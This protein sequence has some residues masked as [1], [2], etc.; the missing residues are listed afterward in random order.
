[1][2]KAGGAALQPVGFTGASSTL[3]AASGDVHLY[4]LAGQSNMVGLANGSALSAALMARL[5]DLSG[6]RTQQLPSPTTRPRT[7]AAPR[8]LMP[9]SLA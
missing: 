3:A 9:A 8:L 6:R 7:R 5:Q 2:G 1:M 4:F